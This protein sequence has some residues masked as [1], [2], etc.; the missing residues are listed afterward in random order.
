MTELGSEHPAAAS[1][2][3]PRALAAMTLAIVLWTT[4]VYFVRKADDIL[5]F[6]TWRMVLAIPVLAATAAVLRLRPAR[7][8]RISR[9]PLRFDVRLGLVAIGVLFGVSALVNFSALNETTLVNVGV[10]HAL[11]PAVVALLAGRVLGELVDWGLVARIGLAIIGACL[12]AAASAGVG[13]WSL[14][15]DVLA[16]LG[17]GLNSLWFLAGRWVRTRTHLDATTYMAVVFGAAAATLIIAAT[18]AGRSLTV[19]RTTIVLAALTALCGTIGHTLVAWSHRFLQVT[20]SSLFLLSQPVLIAVLAWLAFEERLHPLD[21]VGGTIV[22]ASLTGIVRRGGSAPAV[23][24]AP[25]GMPD[26]I[27]ND[28]VG[29]KVPREPGPGVR[30]SP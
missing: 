10:I 27:D 30:P 14:H 3:P 1:P 20:M 11:Q 17:L 4:N 16:V 8:L 26:I 25:D 13:S 15:G 12:V 19:D 23:A 7:P 5:L 6:T 22:L 2:A 21:V 29:Q 9:E 28:P 24:T 18:I